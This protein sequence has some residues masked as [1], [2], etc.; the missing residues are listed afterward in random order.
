MMIAYITDKLATETRPEIRFIYEAKMTE[1][2]EKLPKLGGRNDD[3]PPHNL[4]SGFARH[5]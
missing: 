2:R 4:R 3:V 5:S 1:W